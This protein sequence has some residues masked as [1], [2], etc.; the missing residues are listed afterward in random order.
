MT[1]SQF[2]AWN[3]YRK[4]TDPNG[5]ARSV[6]VNVRAKIPEIVDDAIEKTRQGLRHFLVIS[7]CDSALCG[8]DVHKTNI[9]EPTGQVSLNQ[10]QGK[11]Q[12]ILRYLRIRVLCVVLLTAAMSFIAPAYGQGNTS[13]YIVGEVETAAALADN[14]CPA[15]YDSRQGGLTRLGCWTNLVPSSGMDSRE[16]SRLDFEWQVGGSHLL[17][18]GMD[19]EEN[20]SD[21]AINQPGV[22]H[23]ILVNPGRDVHTFY[24]LDGDGT[25]EE[26]FLSAA[27]L[28]FP[29]AKRRYHAVTLGLEKKWD[30]VFYVKGLY[31]W[32]HSYGNY[33]RMV[34]SDN[35]QDDAGIT[36]LFDFAGLVDGAYGNLPND[37]RHQITA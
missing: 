19:R 26:L 25:L 6:N 9:N 30:G 18:F 32:A 16:V 24:D 22:F 20:T 4:P 13:G 3:D 5:F 36:T 37:R 34:R 14:I 15:A 17:R 31:T 12:M 23:Y 8:L 27:D 29:K 33:E 2:V 11:L 1:Q 10:E 35:G 21:E 28:G 7:A